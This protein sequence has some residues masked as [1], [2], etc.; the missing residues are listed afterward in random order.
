[1]AGVLSVFSQNKDTVVNLAPSEVGPFCPKQLVA[2]DRDFAGHG[3][4]VWASVEITNTRSAVVAILKYRAKEIGGDNSETT[5]TTLQILY[6]VPANTGTYITGVKGGKKAEVHFIS[7][8]PVTTFAAGTLA[9]S[10][11]INALSVL[12]NNDGVVNKWT[13]YG[14]TNGAD[15]SDDDNCD[16][17]TRILVSLNQL[18][19]TLGQT[20]SS[21][22]ISTIN[23]EDINE[24]LVPHLTRG[25]REFDGH[26]PRIKSEVKLRIG[27]GGTKL[28][29]DV[30]FWAQETVS[31][32]STAEG[33]WSKLVY[34]APYGK[35][36][37]EILS[38]KASRTQ[39]ISPPG[40]F[41]VL[42]PGADL[43]KALNTFFDA[44]DVQ[45]AV[46]KAFGAKPEDRGVLQGLVKGILDHGN[47]V[48]R[49]PPVEGTL[50]KFFHI[51]G[52]T[53]GPDISDDD[54]GN[55]DTRIVKIEFFPVKVKMVNA[56]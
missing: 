55:D 35:K 24:W 27:D 51:V 10:L 20:E 13:I 23:L 52:D 39:F 50:V 29:A 54:N 11:N 8:S 16:D 56:N 53:G 46:M 34:E 17:D 40:G 49:V 43:A 44:T 25:D 14:D 41:Q 47:T 26:G 37:T 6:N 12:D 48:V 36:I 32:W 22:G 42:V 2:G 31:D 15:I 45:P 7:K 30:T 33:S 3:P 5:G 21:Q 1:M 19:V 4:E 38:D 18:Q 28:Y 9:R